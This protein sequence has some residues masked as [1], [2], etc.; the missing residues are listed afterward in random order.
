MSEK[1]LMNVTELSE[2]LS[3]SKGSLYTMVC[4]GKIPAECIVK[5][6]RSLRFD[7]AKIDAWIDSRS[8]ASL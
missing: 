3:I 4:M 7:K 1:R 2:Y 5:I 8:A 6:G